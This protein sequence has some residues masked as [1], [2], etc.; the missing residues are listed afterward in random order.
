MNVPDFVHDDL[1]ALGIALEPRQLEALADYL[2]RVMAANQRMNL[3]AVREEDAAW[4]RL[5]IDSLSVLPG[6][7]ML[8][9]PAKV[10]DIGSGAGLPGLPIAVARPAV[11]VTMLEATGKKAEFIRGCIEA[12]GLTNAQV[13]Q[14]RAEVL[15]QDP[16]HRAGYDA[17]VSRAVGAMPLVLEYSLPLVREGG[18]VL[19]MK[20]PA[21]RAGAGGFGRR[22][23]PTGRRRAGG[24]RRVSGIVWQRPGRRVGNQRPPDPVALPPDTGPPQEAAA[25][26]AVGRVRCVSG[27]RFTRLGLQWRD[28]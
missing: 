13:L 23:G 9:E 24:D 26:G 20:G 1:G 6:V 3:T 25:V 18:R 27:D 15:G 28:E 22:A 5:V 10:I 4:R 16:Q 19:A 11:Q 7:D 12:L 21:R 14:E 8:G 17:A 2:A